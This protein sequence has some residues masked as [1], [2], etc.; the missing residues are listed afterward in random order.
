MRRIL[1]TGMGGA[2]S[3]NFVR[4]LRLSRQD[5]YIVGTEADP[6]RRPL[7]IADRTYGCPRSDHP[8]YLERLSEIV[9]RERIELIHAQPD[10]EVRQLA[11]LRPLLQARTF[12]PTLQTIQLC[13]D[14]FAL[15]QRLA[16]RGVPTPPVRRVCLESLPGVLAELGE[17]LWLRASRGAGGLGSLPISSALQAQGWLDFHA[18]RDMIASPIL[19]GRTFG[20]QAVFSEGALLCGVAW[21][22]VR[23]LI[24]HVSP[25]GVTGVSGISRIVAR[26][27]IDRIGEQAVRAVSAAPHGIFAVDLRE[28]AQQRPCVT[29][30]NPG[31]FISLSLF[32]ARAGANLPLLYLNT[33]LGDPVPAM[34][35][36]SP[37]AI[38]STWLRCIDREP[39]FVPGETPG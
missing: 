20:W 38:G 35:Q 28:D 22:R 17:R 26:E 34:P 25:S 24:P 1:V 14:K 37:A 21:E 27:D 30:I 31:R 19:P 39:V 7:S 3:W 36:R 10:P 6:L 12:L 23:Y 15:Q 29:E 11:A 5:L 9:A 16:D 13:Q 32:F 18:G 33:A 8:G 2:A 4:A